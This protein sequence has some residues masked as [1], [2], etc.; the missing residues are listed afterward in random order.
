MRCQRPSAVVEVIGS[1][2]VLISFNEFHEV[3]DA[4]RLRDAQLLDAL[5]QCVLVAE[6]FDKYF[7]REPRRGPKVKK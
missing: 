5:L 6:E 3:V 4:L 7:P 2:S 1:P